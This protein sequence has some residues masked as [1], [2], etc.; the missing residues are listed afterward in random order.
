[1][2]KSNRQADS[3]AKLIRT[4]KKKGKGAGK[5]DKQPKF[6]MADAYEKWLLQKAEAFENLATLVRIMIVIPSNSAQCERGVS[7]MG[8]IKTT[9]RNRLHDPTLDALMTI[10]SHGNK[11]EL[12][13][14]KLIKKMSK[15][16]Q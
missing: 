8:R 1:M 13:L 7:L 2:K 10:A 16:T 14:K 12:D 11:D 9:K 5:K 15:I 6:N 3:N 4:E